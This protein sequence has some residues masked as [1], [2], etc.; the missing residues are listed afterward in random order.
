MISAIRNLGDLSKMTSVSV[1]KIS[2]K[3]GG[4]GGVK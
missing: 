4:V 1:F 3:L 2:R